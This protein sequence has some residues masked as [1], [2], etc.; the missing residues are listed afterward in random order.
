MKVEVL[1][2]LGLT[3]IVMSVTWLLIGV[4]FVLK[5]RSSALIQA[6]GLVDTFLASLVI[7][8]Y[9][10]LAS[11]VF[12]LGLSCIVRT[13]LAGFLADVAMALVTERCVLL[14]VQFI[15]GKQA[16]EWVQDSSKHFFFLKNKA[17]FRHGLFTPTK[18]IVVLI[19]GLFSL[20]FPLSWS[21]EVRKDTSQGFSCQNLFYQGSVF[22]FILIV[23]CC[24]I[25]CSRLLK[26]V[27]E[28][29]GIKYELR[30]LGKFTIS[31]AFLY[32]LWVVLQRVA[33]LF[34]LTLYSLAVFGA[35]VPWG[36]TYINIYLVLGLLKKRSTAIHGHSTMKSYG[37]SSFDGKSLEAMLEEILINE[38]N[39][40]KDF[41]VREF[42]VENFL[43]LEAVSKFK[44]EKG[45]CVEGAK[46]IYNGFV[47]S[48]ALLQVNLSGKTI[49]SIEEKMS[50]PDED[51]FDE[52]VEAVKAL[53]SSSS[54]PR[55]FNYKRKKSENAGEA[56][57]PI[58]HTI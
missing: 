50:C 40:F 52:A 23:A 6:R 16:E 44:A 41:L 35:Y 55:Y 56:A 34:A 22:A 10:S 58:V 20:P 46:T 1:R 4:T 17:Y 7:T 57:V 8:V 2:G 33:P 18:L 25:Y 51:M 45:A 42:A 13:T 37:T 28:N 19:A 53:L 48:G 12:G 3:F 47:S 30:M 9:A 36:L 21:E 11:S 29:F 49:E 27:E 39:D 38:P 24:L 43:F 32:V 5:R 31:I 14:Y 15:V 26:K 54:L